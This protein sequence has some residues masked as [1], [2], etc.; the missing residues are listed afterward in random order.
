M[1]RPS[2]AEGR[3]T[4]TVRRAATA[5][6]GARKGAR[7]RA[8]ALA[9][10]AAMA[11]VDG[12]PGVTIGALA[13]ETGLSKSG[14]YAHFRSKEALEAAILDEVAAR[15]AQA[16]FDPA[17]A[18][19]ATPEGLDALVERWLDWIDGS[20]YPG[21]CPFQSAQSAYAD[22]PGPARAR[23]VAHLRDLRLALI[24]RLRAAFP[25]LGRRD[26][27]QAAFEIE[28]I[29]QAYAR[30]SRVLGDAK[31][32]AQARAAWTALRGRSTG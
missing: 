10:A 13:A 5:V 11:S 29:V 21:G 27:A 16:V 18:G 20:A 8:R 26:A 15:F 3:P 24:G 32:R 28:G 30:S 12:V 17:A 1:N 19:P 23:L 7:T 22:R 4:G 31:A 25:R 14:L 9:R 6:N 2:A